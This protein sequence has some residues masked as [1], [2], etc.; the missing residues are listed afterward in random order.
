[1][2]PIPNETTD[3]LY[4]PTHPRPHRHGD[5][6][7]QEP[8]PTSQNSRHSPHEDAVTVGLGLIAR[9]GPLVF[10]VSV[11]IIVAMDL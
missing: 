4:L 7:V 11:E 3:P 8:L 1:M 5:L 6:R 9:R 10:T 2:T